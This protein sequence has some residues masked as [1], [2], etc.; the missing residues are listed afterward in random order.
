MPKFNIGDKVRFKDGI[1]TDDSIYTI[2]Q[3]DEFAPNGEA[4]YVVYYC[5]EMPYAI[6]EDWLEA[7]NDA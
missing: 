1:R 6:Y 3:I 4:L 5:D 2:N 7:A